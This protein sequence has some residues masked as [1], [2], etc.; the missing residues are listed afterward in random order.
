M[1]TVKADKGHSSMTSHKFDPLWP[2]NWWFNLTIIYC[3]PP[4]WLHGFIY[5]CPHCYEK[6][7]LNFRLELMLE[8]SLF[9]FPTNLLLTR[10][11]VRSQFVQL[12]YFEE[13]FSSKNEIVWT[14]KEWTIF[15]IKDKEV[16]I[17]LP[18]E[19]RITY[20]HINTRL[21]LVWY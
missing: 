2:T 9:S 3:F 14:P 18:F 20:K 5:E 12:S 10:I 7:P 16:E 8:V 1:K 6:Q 21:F 13:L 15:Y 19:Y 4:P 17:Q 11:N